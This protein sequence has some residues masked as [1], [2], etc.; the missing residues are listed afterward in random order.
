MKM[1]LKHLTWN[2]ALYP[3]HVC[4]PKTSKSR[5]LVLSVG[6]SSCTKTPAFVGSQ[7]TSYEALYSESL[8]FAVRAELREDVYTLRIWLNMQQNNWNT[9]AMLFHLIFI[10]IESK[11]RNNQTAYQSVCVPFRIPLA[12]H[13]YLAWFPSPRTAEH[14]NHLINTKQLYLTH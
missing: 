14:P 10:S 8:I 3:R 12:W 13:H 5:I 2:L 11:A 1:V 6:R 9:I 4:P 7:N